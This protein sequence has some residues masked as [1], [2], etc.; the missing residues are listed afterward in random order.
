MLQF[1]IILI[2]LTAAALIFCTRLRAPKPFLDLPR[3]ALI[4]AAHSDDCVIMG[5]EYSYG[6]IENGYSVKIAYL[7]CSGPHPEADISRVR[8]AEAVAAWSAL[9]IPEKNLTFL[10]LTES[11]VGGPLSYSDQDIADAKKILQSVIVA[12][13]EG[14]AIIIP[15]DGE[16]HVDHRTVRK[17]SLE[18]IAA[19]QR[20]DFLF[21]ETPEYNT[22]LSLIHSP[23][24]TMCTIVRHV[25]LFN[26]IVES[27]AGPPSY[28]EGAAGFVF[29]DTPRRLATKKRLL[30][31]FPSQD[32]ALLIHYFGYATLYRKVSMLKT[33]QA[34]AKPW[35]FVAF[36]S[37]CDA[38]VLG[39][40]IVLLI[41]TW[42]TSYEAARTL[43]LVVMPVI[44]VENW[45]VLL[46]AGVA[47]AYF[48]RRLR[49]TV[50]LETSL[51]VWVAASGIIFGGVYQL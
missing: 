5:A 29:Q 16:S 31:F 12:L 33:M 11:P 50:S 39:M 47:S 32:V 1:D 14:A 35:R 37:Y 19:S 41:I 17:L 40:G 13:P 44:H 38:S 51:L 4:C 22:F 30:G 18:A 24:R 42:L 36:G 2:L 28:T 43:T 48:V 26:R 45:L 10:N 6:A 49:R 7:T 8:R 23:K 27:Y 21:Y 46:G 15:A 20:H 34:G 25:P 9:G 3:D